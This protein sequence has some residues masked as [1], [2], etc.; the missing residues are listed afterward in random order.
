LALLV[1]APLLC[2]AA[3]PGV[4]VAVGLCFLS[5]TGASYYL[6]LQRRLLDVVPSHIR[7]QAFGLIFT[8]I[9]A[10]SG[11]ALA[12]AGGLATWVASSTGIALVGLASGLSTIALASHLR[13]R[14]ALSRL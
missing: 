1:A 7:A 4:V 12:L 13:L 14:A 10:L 9:P 3:Q 6:G 11:I 2:F 5:A 8:G